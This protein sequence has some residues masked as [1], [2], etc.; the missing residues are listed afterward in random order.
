LSISIKQNGFQMHHHRSQSGQ[1]EKKKASISQT[2]QNIHELLEGNK[3]YQNSSSANM[4]KTNNTSNKIRSTSKSPMQKQKIVMSDVLKEV[5]SL[6]TNHNR[7]IN[8]GFT[9]LRLNLN[10]KVE[11]PPSEEPASKRKEITKT[12][13]MPSGRNIQVNIKD[14]K[15]NIDQLLNE[16]NRERINLEMAG[17]FERMIEQEVTRSNYFFKDHHKMPLR[18]INETDSRRG[19]GSGY[20]KNEMFYTMK[21]HNNYIIDYNANDLG[22]IKS[23]DRTKMRVLQRWNSQ[24]LNSDDDVSKDFIRRL[25]KSPPSMGY[26]TQEMSINFFIFI[27]F[28]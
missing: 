14:I 1:V 23:L 22:G 8:Q 15:G 16:K 25:R 12:I 27:L 26:Q 17:K 20:F 5:E 3:K 7:K 4:Q 10:K 13:F 28:L 19:G 21:S 9:N 24:R 11:P 6:V 18:Y 2:L